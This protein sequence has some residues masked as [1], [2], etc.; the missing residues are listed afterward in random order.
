MAGN[1]SGHRLG[2]GLAPKLR[3]E[4]DVKAATQKGEI[5]HANG[6]PLAACRLQRGGLVG[7]RSRM[8]P[9][10]FVKF[11]RENSMLIHRPIR[12]CASVSPWSPKVITVEINQRP[13]RCG[14]SLGPPRARCGERGQ[15]HGWPV[16]PSADA[17]S[18][19]R[20]APRVRA[21]R[22]VRSG[23]H[24]ASGREATS[25]R[26]VEGAG[27][28]ASRG[29]ASDQTTAAATPHPTQGA[30][31]CDAFANARSGCPGPG[32]DKVRCRS[33]GMVGRNRGPGGIG[34]NSH[35]Q[36][37]ARDGGCGIG[38][39]YGPFANA[40]VAGAP[41][42]ADDRPKVRPSSLWSRSA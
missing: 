37:L 6:Q 27:G 30:G 34:R 8:E 29:A 24:E 41:G 20:S 32:I 17:R 40:R 28:S 21:C 5:R 1:G 25:A 23:W 22:H 3:Q 9:F 31:A 18:G 15:A 42:Q 36:P 38:F 7:C 13:G 14:I 11:I 26:S 4:V 39:T 12:R 19:R 35:D 10:V 33:G 16:L 2:P